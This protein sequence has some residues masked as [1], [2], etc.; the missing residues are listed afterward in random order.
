IHS[1]LRQL[2]TEPIWGCRRVPMRQR[3]ELS[4]RPRG[5]DNY[6]RSICGHCA[7]PFSRVL[8]IS[9]RRE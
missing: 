9:R 5:G 4:T 6:S 1:D 3:R 2:N 8:Y 7:A